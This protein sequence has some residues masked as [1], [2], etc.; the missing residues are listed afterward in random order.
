MPRRLQIKVWLRIP[1]L[2][3]ALIILL[4]RYARAWNIPAHML[5]GG[6]AMIG[7]RLPAEFSLL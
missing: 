1:G 5:S 2:L 4:P 7:W 3:T 6:L